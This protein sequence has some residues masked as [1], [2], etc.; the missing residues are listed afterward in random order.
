MSSAAVFSKSFRRE[1]IVLSKNKIV[2]R[3]YLKAEKRP[4]IFQSF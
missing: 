2:K 3:Y 4:A 1:A